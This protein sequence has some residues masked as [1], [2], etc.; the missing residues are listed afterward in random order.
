ME[1]IAQ[2][3]RENFS[4]YYQPDT[5]VAV[6]KC[7]QGFR[8]R[9]SDIINILTKPTPIGFKIWCLAQDSY[10]LDFLW[11]R[12]GDKPSQGPQGLQSK[13]KEQGFCPTQAV[14]L[15]LVTRM[16]NSGQNHTV[17]LDNLFTTSRL[18]STLRD[19]GIGAAGT[20]RTGQTAREENAAKITS[21]QAS[22]VTAIEKDAS[23]AIT[24]DQDVS[25]AIAVDQDA[26]QAIV[27]DEEGRPQRQRKRTQKALELEAFEQEFGREFSPNKATTLAALLEKEI[28]EQL[29]TRV[30]SQPISSSTD[31]TSTDLAIMHP[32]STS[33]MDMR[34]VELKTRFGS[35]LQWG[36]QF[37]TVTPD[38]KVLQL[39][40]KDAQ[41]VLF[42]STV[43]TP[44]EMIVKPRKKPHKKTKQIRQIW[45]DSYVKNLPIPVYIDDYNT[46]MGSVDLADQY[47]ASY[48]EKRRTCR[49]W[50]PLFK[51]LV[52]STIANA[53]KIWI[54]Q[55][56]STIKDSASHKFR[57][58]LATSLLRY[59]Q[60]KQ[61]HRQPITWQAVSKTL[62]TE[63]DK[64]WQNCY[65]SHTKLSEVARA[66]IIYAGRGSL[67]LSKRRK[68][69]E[70]TAS[71]TNSRNQAPRTRYGC[72]RC[73]IFI[74]R[75]ALCWQQHMALDPFGQ[76]GVDQR[77][78]KG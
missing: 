51:F 10:I 26:S 58:Q 25:Q 55:G 16:R 53:V 67:P 36:E 14:V 44:Q 43:S 19:L 49:T 50:I 13:W 39:A 73:N 2:I 28:S 56:H 47:R 37:A 42:M 45:G 52:Q 4:K 18:L 22:Q 63:S 70:L 65:G 9:C 31:P 57:K 78:K 17:W 40:W 59:S 29:S 21:K 48:A 68:L 6:D 54:A 27:T 15:E 20:V 66:C 69:Q 35:L 11:H 32:I 30:L 41:T 23:Q 72:D 77:T 75:G 46:N 34:L 62:S 76:R 8:G 60:L 61:R 24:V 64:K 38:D 5:N 71:Q 3:L 12:R 74:C 33:G 1:P 7:I